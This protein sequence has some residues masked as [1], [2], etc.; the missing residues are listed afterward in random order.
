M[1]TF[2]ALVI[3]LILG[4]TFVGLF[5]LVFRLIVRPSADEPRLLQTADG[6]F[7][8]VGKQVICDHCGGAKFHAREIL[9]NTWVL[10]L[11]RIDWLDSSA[12]VLS[13][14]ACGRITWFSQEKPAGPD[15]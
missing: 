3:L 13:C 6:G 4:L 10:S 5:I 11:L 8:V 15:Q 1:S 7:T 14:S 9:L 2:L 12:T